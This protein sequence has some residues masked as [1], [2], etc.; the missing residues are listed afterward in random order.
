MKLA[1]AEE[2]SA[3]ITKITSGLVIAGTVFLEKKYTGRKV[4]HNQE[5]GINARGATKVPPA[6]LESNGKLV[7]GSVTR[8]IAQATCQVGERMRSSRFFMSVS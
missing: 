2:T 1:A 4:R 8:V 3:R 6:A 7:T 5:S